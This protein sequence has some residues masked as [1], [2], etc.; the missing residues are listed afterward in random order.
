M[1]GS[2]GKMSLRGAAVLGGGRGS[3]SSRRG[4]WTGFREGGE[5]CPGRARL[6]A[7]MR[8]AKSLVYQDEQWLERCDVSINMGM[9]KGVIGHAREECA[10]LIYRTDLLIPFTV[11]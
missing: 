7:G 9:E 10:V 5:A 1:T 3:T 11:N 4:R 8:H 2:S 6:A